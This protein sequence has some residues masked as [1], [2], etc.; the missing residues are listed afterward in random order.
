MKLIVENFQSLKKAEIEIPIG[1][2]SITGPSDIG[3]SAIVR[4]FQAAVFGWPSYWF[5]RNGSP[6]CHVYEKKF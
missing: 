5:V 1:F 2:T 4:A 6:Y 3:K